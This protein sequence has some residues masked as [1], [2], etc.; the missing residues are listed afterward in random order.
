M[1]WISKVQMKLALR[2]SAAEVFVIVV[3]LVLGV[4]RFVFYLKFYQD[5]SI[6]GGS[7]N[8][9]SGSIVN[10]LS[11]CKSGTTVMVCALPA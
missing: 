6:E 7:S 10:T 11:I 5:S 4:I 1:I 3:E 8:S 9:S 2:T